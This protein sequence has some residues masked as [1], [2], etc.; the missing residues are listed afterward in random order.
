[1]TALFV[2]GCGA[3]TTQRNSTTGRSAHEPHARAIPYQ[4]YTHCGVEWARIKGTFWRAQHPLSD[5]NGKPPA[6]WG[7]PFQ[8]GMLTFTNAKNA[9]FASAAGTV[10]FDRTD[11]ARPPLICS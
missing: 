4:L 8:P 10:I 9:R 7:N 3:G 2:L 1:M 5:G 11:R 6:G